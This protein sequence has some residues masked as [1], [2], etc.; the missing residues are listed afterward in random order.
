MF[1]LILCNPSPL[2]LT[3]AIFPTFH[4]GFF[5]FSFHL[6]DRAEGWDFQC[7]VGPGLG[8][9]YDNITLPFNVY[10]YVCKI[11]ELFLRRAEDEF[12]STS[13]SL[14]EIYAKKILDPSG[15]PQT[16]PSVY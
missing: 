9:P 2:H 14:T 1:F 13:R 12:G 7:L 15:V 16:C 8:N 6:A 5:S 4:G 10:F 11:Y 3:G